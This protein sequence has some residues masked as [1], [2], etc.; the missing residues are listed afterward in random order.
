MFLPQIM[1]EGLPPTSTATATNT[2]SV[3]Q[4]A[5]ATATAS[6]TPSATSTATA[7]ATPTETPVACFPTSGTY[8]IA[9]RDTLLNADGF[10]NPD[11]YYSDETYQNK[12]WKRVSL[13]DW[14]NPNGGFDW[15]RWRAAF[16]SINIISFTASL[17]GTGNLGEAFDESPWP[18]NSSLPKP[19]GYPQLPHQLNAGDWT[20]FYPGVSNSSSVRTALDNHIVNRTVM[21]LPIY[22][23]YSLVG[24]D[25]I[26]HISRGGAFLLL[27][28]NLSSM[29]NQTYLT[30]VYIG[31]PASCPE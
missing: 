15:Q 24:N 30:L 23:A 16:A 1:R 17:T 12:S 4:T 27:D 20:Y 28:Y 26:Y 29:S 14:S 3:T 22:D 7:T 25:T 19:S 8:P 21:I 9:V 5:T 31:R 6:V 18:A 10:V 11:G 13:R 2:P